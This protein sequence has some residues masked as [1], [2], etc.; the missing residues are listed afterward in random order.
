MVRPQNKKG[1]QMKLSTRGKTIITTVV[2]SSI[3]W[4]GVI[5]SVKA[6]IHG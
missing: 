6:A 2:L 4:A 5:L 1:Y 3:F